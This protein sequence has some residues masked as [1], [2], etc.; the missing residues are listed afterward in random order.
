MHT[1]LHTIFAYGYGYLYALVLGNIFIR[2]ITLAIYADW[3]IDRDKAGNH[4]AVLGC[5]EVF[6]YVS[7]IKVGKPEF[8]AFWIGIKTAMGWSHWQQLEF[9]H[10]NPDGTKIPIPGRQSFNIFL[11]GTGLTIS[12]SLVGSQLITWLQQFQFVTAAAGALG[13]VLL[14]SWLYW[15]LRPLKILKA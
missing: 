1:D 9:K 12:F 15:I 11:T 6:L 2:N 14:A 3:Q 10:V 7:A 5:I 13:T 4:S 8:I